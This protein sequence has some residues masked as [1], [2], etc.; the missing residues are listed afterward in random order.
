MCIRVENLNS[1]VLVFGKKVYKKMV[2]NLLFKTVKDI[3]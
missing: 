1:L 3:K 2:F